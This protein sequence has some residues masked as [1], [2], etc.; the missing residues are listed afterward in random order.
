MLEAQRQ[1]QGGFISADDQQQ[2]RKDKGWG[3]PCKALDFTNHGR[4]SSRSPRGELSSV[5]CQVMDTAD[6]RRGGSCW[7]WKD[8][9]SLHFGCGE[10]EAQHVLSGQS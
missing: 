1:P 8:L 7:D 5:N 2:M 9:P 4:Y 3:L 6:E 10:T